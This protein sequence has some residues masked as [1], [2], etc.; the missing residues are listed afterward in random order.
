M[1]MRDLKVTCTVDPDDDYFILQYSADFGLGPI[2][3]EFD[4]L[5]VCLNA[6]KTRRMVQW[7]NNVLDA[8]DSEASLVEPEVI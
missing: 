6:A 7:L 1:L 5:K 8:M 3:V 4:G 2:S